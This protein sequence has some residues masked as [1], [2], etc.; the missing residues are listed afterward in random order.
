ME[1]LAG[2][3]SE[4]ASEAGSSGDLDAG[5]AAAL[6][7]ETAGMVDQNLSL[8][9]D[10]LQVLLDM[11]LPSEIRARAQRAFRLLEE[12]ETDQAG[13]ELE[14]IVHDLEQTGGTP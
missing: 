7:R 11:S 13:Q 9:M 3:P 5:Q 2:R 4:S 1:E 8:A 6:A 14:K 12:V 10:K